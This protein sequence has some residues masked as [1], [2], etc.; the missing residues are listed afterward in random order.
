[1][2]LNLLLST[3]A[4]A[5]I[6]NYYY[7]ENGRLVREENIDD[8]G[9][10]WENV[11]TY[12]DDGKL[13]YITWLNNGEVDGKEVY[14]YDES[15]RQST[16]TTYMSG[17]D[18]ANNTPSEKSVYTY[19]EN[20]VRTELFYDIAG[21]SSEEPWNKIITSYDSNGNMISETM[22]NGDEA[23]ASGVFNWT[24]VYT[25]D[26]NG[27]QTSMKWY[28]STEA[29][30]NDRPDYMQ[31]Y[32][33]DDHG[34]MISWEEYVGYESIENGIPSHSPNWPYRYEYDEY[35]NIIA[36]YY[37]NGGEYVLGFTSYWANP[38]WKANSQNSSNNGNGESDTTQT[39]NASNMA[40]RGK[41][42]YTVEEATRVSKKTGNTFK[43]RYK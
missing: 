24:G 31:I 32:I 8:S 2:I 26:E 1:M 40:R 14:T 9:V 19:D 28:Y 21:W 41:L 13:S 27:A 43:I 38:N 30:E 17:E 6:Y 15:G 7:D 37:H 34:S 12:D 39:S 16:Y 36:M 25:Y 22:Y 18:V 4:W 5:E 10:K 3:T 29:K 11:Y 23:I 35:G 33:N 20:G 42:I